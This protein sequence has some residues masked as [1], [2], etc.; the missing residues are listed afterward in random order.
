MGHH[1][2]KEG[3]KLLIRLGIGKLRTQSCTCPFCRVDSHDP[4]TLSIPRL[5][6]VTECPSCKRCFGFGENGQ[7]QTCINCQSDYRIPA[8]D[9]D[10]DRNSACGTVQNTLAKRMPDG[11]LFGYN[12]SV[13]V[14]GKCPTCNDFQWVRII[15]P[16][17][18]AFTRLIY[19]FL[20]NVCSPVLRIGT[21]TKSWYFASVKRLPELPQ[22]WN[23]ASS[24]ALLLLKMPSSSVSYQY[25]GLTENKSMEEV[26]TDMCFPVVREL[27]WNA[28]REDVVRA[29]RY[30]DR[31]SETKTENNMDRAIMKHIGMLGPVK[32]EQPIAIIHFFKACTSANLDYS[33][34]KML[35]RYAAVVWNIKIDSG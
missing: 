28:E 16:E 4:A 32:R 7:L 14:F 18:S 26:L 11:H 17:D 30:G 15:G 24:A 19:R 25:D 2:S 33:R 1:L 12:A 27:I 35:A 34:D 6:S 5:P 22:N 29:F 3:T 10:I 13:L 8:S 23:H 20:D 31:L 21:N 9:A